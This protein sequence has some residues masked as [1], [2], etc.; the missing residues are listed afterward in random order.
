MLQLPRLMLVTQRERMRPDFFGAL[1]AALRG[2]A[3]LIQLREKGLSNAEFVALARRAQSLCVQ[4][5]AILLLNNAPNLARTLGVGLH[6][7]ESALA[8][9]GEFSPRG[10]SV[11]SLGAARCAV[12]QGADY[13][14]FGAVFETQTHPGAA[15]AGLE[16]LC[17]VCAAVEVP[18]FAIGGITA[19]NAKTCLAAG[20]HGVAVIGAAWDA[21]D[22]EAAVRELAE[23]HR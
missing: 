14:V 21:A 15:P 17:E 20:A 4:H 2:G 1:E 19:A 11:H 16:A 7:P 6:L 9:E 13:L 8:V 5:G 10:V 18:I 12:G 3:R 23:I 22:V